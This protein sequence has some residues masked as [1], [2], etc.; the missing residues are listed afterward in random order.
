MDYKSIQTAVDGL[1]ASIDSKFAS[2]DAQIA[3]MK[4]AMTVVPQAKQTAEAEYK[5]FYDYVKTGQKA[6][7]M[8][9][10]NQTG[11]AAEV[12]IPK[13]EGTDI[14]DKIKDYS[15][16]LADMHHIDVSGSN[17]MAVPVF[18]T[19]VSPATVAEGGAIALDNATVDIATIELSKVASQTQFTWEMLNAYTPYSL[20]DEV[21]SQVI[22]EIGDKIAQQATANILADTS[23]NNVKTANAT[24]VT[25][26]D[27]LDAVASLP[28]AA[29]AGAK[30]YMTK[31]TF[32]SKILGQ[33]GTDSNYVN[34]PY[35]VGADPL[36]LGKPVRFVPEMPAIAA[37]SKS[38]MY[39]NLEQGTRY[40]T[41]GGI[42][43]L[44]DDYTMAKNGA[45]VL[46]AYALAGSGVVRPEAIT[47]LQQKA[48]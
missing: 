33:F 1:S 27:L 34:M 14:L 26:Q 9:M 30:W 48:Q 2:F 20:M 41:A 35:Q 31:S 19:T 43:T 24:K 10:T 38:I 6:A 29:D 40:A 36:L 8:A 15:P 25:Y 47:V 28:N 42:K 3:E 46:W 21:Q 4:N 18:K 7:S 16:I 32:Y 45:V 17:G 13:Y 12:A 5:A 39:A 23:V 44:R 11:N 22:T 37:S